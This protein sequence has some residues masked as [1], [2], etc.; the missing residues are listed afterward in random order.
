[1]DSR[2]LLSAAVSL[3][4]KR[5]HFVYV[6]LAAIS[7]QIAVFEF[8]WLNADIRS[9]S[10]D[11]AIHLNASLDCLEW[12][13]S[14]DYSG[15]MKII[16]NKYPP[17][18]PFITSL[19]YVIWGTS[20]NVAYMSN[21]FFTV[22]MVFSVYFIGK[23][24]YQPEAGLLAA[25]FVAFYP[26]FIIMSHEY[27]LDYAGASALTLA[28]M[29]LVLT[30]SFQRPLMSFFAGLTLTVSLLTR[31]YNIIF[32]YAPVSLLI[33]QAW[34]RKSAPV[35]RI[36]KSIFCFL[37]PITGIYGLY[38]YYSSTFGFLSY[39]LAHWKID[40]STISFFLNDVIKEIF[41]AQLYGWFTV[42]LISA[43]IG[44]LIKRKFR[45]HAIPLAWFAGSLVIL[46]VTPHNISRYSMGFLPALALISAEW[47]TGLKN[48]KLKM[49]IISMTIVLGLVQ[50]VLM[51]IPIVSSI[52]IGN[53]VLTKQLRVTSF[54]GAESRR[55]NIPVFPAYTS[56]FNWSNDKVVFE[57]SKIQR[58]YHLIKPKILIASDLEK[59]NYWTLLYSLRT[60]NLNANLTPLESNV[61]L[62]ESE[63]NKWDIVVL[64]PAHSPTPEI[65][66]E[67]LDFLKKFNR[68]IRSTYPDRKE[69]TVQLAFNKK[70]GIYSKHKV[71][72]PQALRRSQNG[73]HLN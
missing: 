64:G 39:M 65:D 22:I 35:K 49:G 29:F 50:H 60:N 55:I 17:V 72:S 59:F 18:F 43:A 56:K 41:Y 40:R 23:K 32:L 71:H 9:P 3:I 6:L 48:R 5:K 63:F 70:I 51:T 33:I 24:L 19:F 4:F 68:F 15:F 38:L 31:R 58:K 7:L 47:I 30:D 57:I 69:T 42:I 36:L 62:K 66:S 53:I 21:I 46:S 73:Y 45:L 27:W 20:L 16:N 1:M 11:E 26:A 14:P 25:F 8:V 44:I 34:L 2:E 10:C 67:H 28:M 12:I 61:P 52:H 37:L 13:R 54:A